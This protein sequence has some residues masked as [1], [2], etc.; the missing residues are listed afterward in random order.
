M[1]AVVYLMALLG[2]GEGEAPCQQIALLETGYES[3]AAC[4]AATEAALAANT[5]DAYP[6]VVA[7]CYDGARVPEVRP[8]EVL[9]AFRF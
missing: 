8:Q 2:C 4:I 5:N 6:L 3:R 9:D 7:Q 1:T